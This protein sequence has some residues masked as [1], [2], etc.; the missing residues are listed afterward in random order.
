MLCIVPHTVPRVGQDVRTEWGTGPPGDDVGAIAL[1]R[2][3]PYYCRTKSGVPL[4]WELEEPKGPIRA[5]AP[6]SSRGEL[7]PHAVLTHD[8]EE[9]GKR[10]LQTRII[11]GDLSDLWDGFEPATA[12]HMAVP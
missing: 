1:Y 7:V 2:D 11:A 4:W 3:Q 10:P 5:L 6:T 8:A 9:S 12:G